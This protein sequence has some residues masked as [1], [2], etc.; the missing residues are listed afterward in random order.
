MASLSKIVGQIILPK[1]KGKQ[2]GQASPPGFNPQRSLMTSSTYRQHL[3][4]L[5]NSRTANDSRTLLNDLVNHDPDVS[6]AV[7]AYLTTAQAAEMVIYAYDANNQI[8]A[9]GIEQ[10]NAIISAMTTINDY[11]LGFS[12]K[13]TLHDVINSLRYMMLLRGSVGVELVLNK[14]LAPDELRLIDTATLRWQQAK[15]GVL[16]PEQKVPGNSEWVSLDVPTFFYGSYHQNPTDM[17]SYSPFVSA[18]NTIAARTEVINE[19]YRIMKIVGYPRLDVTVMEDVLL[20]NAPPSIRQDPDQVRAF[21]R[22]ELSNIRGTISG[23]EAD[24]ALVHSNAFEAKV[25]NDK[26]PSAGLQIQSVID[27]LDSQN[28]AALKVM[29][30]VIGKASN[31]TTASTEARLF[32]LSADALNR[33][34]AG[35]LSAAL[36]FGARMAGYQGR[37]EVKFRPVELRPTLELEPQLTMR[38]A[39]LKD[40]LSLG[41][42]TDAEYH[43]SLYDRPPPAGAPQL[44]G[45]GFLN[46]AEPGASVDTQNISPN[47][48]SL[49]RGLAPKG[50]K[51]AKSNGV[52]PKKK[53]VASG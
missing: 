17:Y 25:I 8:D 3:I 37:I 18:L 49:G 16:K 52:A 19:L 43:M 10:A 12:A 4:D 27:V 34:T 51:S 36:T 33:A 5:Y 39:R 23:L 50:S 7:H 9:A 26:N 14:Q 15:P 31:A 47:G 30:A 1:G 42:I 29:P 35:P 45:T 21:V 40:D 24:Q 6:A 20:A 13:R 2:G 48:D 41:I 38:A 11:S 53:P 44:S 32:A 46:A 22:S 28:Q